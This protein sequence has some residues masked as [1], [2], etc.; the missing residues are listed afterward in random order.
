MDQAINAGLAYKE[1]WEALEDRDLTRE[2]VAAVRKKLEA[3]AGE[4][5]DVLQLLARVLMI[6][7]EA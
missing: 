1:A 3:F 7:E 5:E 4:T 6:R 2:E